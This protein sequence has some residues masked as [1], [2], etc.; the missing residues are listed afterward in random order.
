MHTND[1]PIDPK[2]LA[3]MG[4]ERRDVEPGSLAKPAIVLF[5]GTILAGIIGAGLIRWWNIVPEVAVEQRPFVKAQPPKDTPILQNNSSATADIADL[6][7]HEAEVLTSRGD[8]PGGFKHITIDDAIKLT[9]QRGLPET[10]TQTVTRPSVPQDFPAPGPSRAGT[11]RP[12]SPPPAAAAPQGNPA[13][14]APA[15]TPAGRPI[16]PPAPKGGKQ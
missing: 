12:S 7:R 8:M 11:A 2:T 14:G 3:E 1:E 16:R 15:T 6:R 10:G 5:G 4:Y 9:V 13:P